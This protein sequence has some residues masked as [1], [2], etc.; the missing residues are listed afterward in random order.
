MAIAATLLATVPDAL[1]KRDYHALRCVSSIA[2][3]TRRSGRSLQV[4]LSEKP[5]APDPL[6]P[7]YFGV[8]GSVPRTPPA[9]HR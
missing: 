3:V 1:P 7:M 4:V 9:H 8:L 2:P 6:A 5:A